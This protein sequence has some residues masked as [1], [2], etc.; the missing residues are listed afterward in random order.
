MTEADWPTCADPDRMLDYLGP[1]ISERKLRLYACACCRRIE[2]LITVPD[3]WR[4]V[5]VAEQYADGLVT[6]EE[7]G[8]AFDAAQRSRSVF[9][10]A[11]AP[12]ALVTSLEFNGEIAG[13]AP[14]QVAQTLAQIVAAAAY[15]RARAA[16]ATGAPAESRSAAWA[17][18]DAIFRRALAEAQQVHADLLREI[19]G[20][21]FR[22]V[23]PPREGSTDLV[24]LAAALYDGEDCSFALH[25]ALLEIGRDDLAE[26][27]RTA[28]HP[29][30][31][32]ALDLILGR[33]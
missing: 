26:H 30:G 5:E 11:N 20:N 18:Y 22:P 31:C 24:S 32:W 19:V 6:A 21:P 12:A 15:N 4:S 25:D 10:D 28:R 2:H 9:S 33:C 27:F 3:C 17:D 29:K 23:E 14:M 16:N 8:A 7:C 1:R 13:E